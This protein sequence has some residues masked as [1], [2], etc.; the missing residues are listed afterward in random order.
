[1]PSIPSAARGIMVYPRW[2]SLLCALAWV[3][4]GSGVV[5]DV[6]ANLDP[7]VLKPACSTCRTNT[8]ITFKWTHIDHVVNSYE[9]EYI[10]SE[11]LKSLGGNAPICPVGQLCRDKSWASYRVTSWNLQRTYQLPEI[12][13]TVGCSVYNSKACQGNHSLDLRPSTLYA[14]RVKSCVSTTSCGVYS[15]ILFIPTGQ[16]ALSMPQKSPTFCSAVGA[17][18]GIMPHLAVTGQQKFIAM[19][20]TFDSEGLNKFILA[21]QGPNMALTVVATRD[22]DWAFAISKV[23]HYK[24]QS[25]YAT[26]TRKSLVW[27]EQQVYDGTIAFTAAAAT[28]AVGQDR[29]WSLTSGKGSGIYH[30]KFVVERDVDPP[31]TWVSLSLQAGYFV[32]SVAA[33]KDEWFVITSKGVCDLPAKCKQ[34]FIKSTDGT[35]PADKIDSLYAEGFRTTTMGF[36]N[37]VW[38]I[39][40]MTNTGFSDQIRIVSK[41]YPTESELQTYQTNGYRVTTAAGD[42]EDWVVVLSKISTFGEP[43]L[44]ECHN[45]GELDDTTC[46][47]KC[48][49]PWFGDTDIGGQKG[50]GCTLKPEPC[51]LSVF[52]EYQECPVTC[53]GDNRRRNRTIIREPQYGGTSCE[54]VNC[55]MNRQKFVEP[56]EDP[57]PLVWR[58]ETWLNMS[59]DNTFYLYDDKGIRRSSTPAPPDAKAVYAAGGITDVYRHK[60]LG[61]WF[62]IYLFWLDEVVDN[63]STYC[64]TLDTSASRPSWDMSY[65][66]FRHPL[67]C[68]VKG[69]NG[70]PVVKPAVNSTH[71]YRFRRGR[72]V[73]Y[74]LNPGDQDK[75][76]LA[77]VTYPIYRQDTGESLAKVWDKCK[78][79]SGCWEK[80][81]WQPLKRETLLQIQRPETAV[82]IDASG[83]F[84]EKDPK[85]ILAIEISEGGTQGELLLEGPIDMSPG[86]GFRITDSLCSKVNGNFVAKTISADLKT[87]SFEI[88]EGAGVTD[89]ND[90]G[91]GGQ[92][93]PTVMIPIDPSFTITWK[94]DAFAEDL[95]VVPILGGQ[96]RHLWVPAPV[97]P[98]FIDVNENFIRERIPE[99]RLIS[100]GNGDSAR[101]MALALRL[102]K[103]VEFKDV[104]KFGTFRI[105]I[106]IRDL[107]TAE[108]PPQTGMALIPIVVDNCEPPEVRVSW[109]PTVRVNPSDKTTFKGTVWFYGM[110]DLRRAPNA[111]RQMWV[112]NKQALTLNWRSIEAPGMHTLYET[113]DM[114]WN[115][116]FLKQ[117]FAQLQTMEGLQLSN[118][119][120]RKRSMDPG[121]YTF[122]FSASDL[123]SA[124][125]GEIYQDITVEV[126]TPPEGGQLLISNEG[127]WRHA[128]IFNESFELLMPGWNDTEL[129]IPL[130]YYYKYMLNEGSGWFTS[131]K[132]PCDI[133]D[134]DEETMCEEVPVSAQP[135]QL[136]HNA[137]AKFPAGQI[138]V[139]GYVV[140][141]NGAATRWI[142]LGDGTEGY[143]IANVSVWAPEMN[144]TEKMAMLA[145]QAEDLLGGNT[146]ADPDKAISS[147]NAMVGML[148]DANATVVCC[149]GHGNCT[150][151]PPDCDWP[152]D[153]MC[154][155]TQC[156]CEENWQ[157][158]FCET[159]SGELLVQKQKM[160]DDMMQ[161]MSGAANAT[162]G[163][164]NTNNTGGAAEALSKTLQKTTAGAGELSDNS[165][166][167]ATDMIFNL[168]EAGSKPGEQLPLDAGGPA[169]GA[170]ANLIKAALK[171]GSCGATGD[172]LADTLNDLGTALMG[173]NVP[174]EKSVSIAG[175]GIQMSVQPQTLDG[176]STLKFEVVPE[177]NCSAGPQFEFPV[178]LLGHEVDTSSEMA[179][180]GQKWDINRF[181]DGNVTKNDSVLGPAPSPW[182]GDVPEKVAAV[183][184]PSPGPSETNNTMISGGKSSAKPVKRGLSGMALNQRIHGLQYGSHIAFTMPLK[185][186]F[187]GGIRGSKCQYME[188][189]TNKFSQDGTFAIGLT[190]IKRC[191]VW[192]WQ[193]LCATSHLTDF[194]PE[195]EDAVPEMN[196]PDPIGDA[197]AVANFSA[198]SIHVPLILGILTLLNFAGIWYGVKNDRLDK[199]KYEA[200]MRIEFLKKGI[201]NGDINENASFV[202]MCMQ[203]IRATH[204]ILSF[205]KPPISNA[206]IFRR[207]ERV[208]CTYAH[209]LSSLAVSSLFYGKDPNSI[210]KK[211]S[212]SIITS[213]LMFP[214]SSAFPNSFMNIH[215]LKSKT[216]RKDEQVLDYAD[217]L[218]LSE[219]RLPDDFVKAGVGRDPHQERKAR[220]AAEK[221]RQEELEK[222]KQEAHD[223]EFGVLGGAAKKAMGSKVAPE[224]DSQ[225]KPLNWDVS[226]EENSGSGSEY[227]IES[228]SE[229]DVAKAKTPLMAR[230]A[231]AKAQKSGK[232]MKGPGAAHALM[233]AAARKHKL[234][235][236]ADGIE[237]IDHIHA[238]KLEALKHIHDKKSDVDSSNPQS[239][240]KAV[241]GRRK[242]RGKVKKIVKDPN[243]PPNKE[244]MDEYELGKYKLIVKKYNTKELVEELEKRGVEPALVYAN[245]ER[246]MEQLKN[247]T[248]DETRLTPDEIRDIMLEMSK[249]SEE[250]LVEQLKVAKVEPESKLEKDPVLLKQLMKNIDCIN[251]EDEKLEKNLKHMD[252]ESVINALK[253]RGVTPKTDLASREELIL[254]LEEYYGNAIL[255]YPEQLLKQLK[256]STLNKS[257]MSE[258]E[259]KSAS[260]EMS[261]MTETE[262]IEQLKIANVVPIDKPDESSLTEEEKKKKLDPVKEKARI[263]KLTQV[264]A[265]IEL[266]KLNLEPKRNGASLKELKQQLVHHIHG[267]EDDVEELKACVV[268]WDENRILQEMESY[269][270]EPAIE[271]APK[272]K[273]QA[274]LLAIRTKDAGYEKLS[275]KEKKAVQKQVK[276]YTV[277][278]L[279][280]EIEQCGQEPENVTAKIS[281]LKAQMLD[282]FDGGYDEDLEDSPEFSDK[283][284]KRMTLRQIEKEIKDRGGKIEYADAKKKVIYQQLYENT[285]FAKMDES[286]KKAR[287]KIMKS[288]DVLELKY[289][290]KKKGITPR[291]LLPER[292]ELVLELEQLLTTERYRRKMARKSQINTKIDPTDIDTTLVDPIDIEYEMDLLEEIG[293]VAREEKCPVRC[294]EMAKQ[295][296]MRWL[297]LVR[298]MEFE[299][300]VG[301]GSE[302]RVQ[303]YCICVALTFFCLFVIYMNLLFG[304]LFEPSQSLGWMMSCITTL[305]QGAVL[306]EPIG[307]C[308]GVL[309]GSKL[310]QLW[311]LLNN[312]GDKVDKE[313]DAAILVQ[314]AW[315]AKKEHRKYMAMLKDKRGA[316]VAMEETR[317]A[318][319]QKFADKHEREIQAATTIQAFM[320][321]C[322]D[323][324]RCVTIRRELKAR[325][326]R[327]RKQKRMNVMA[328]IKGQ[329][330]VSYNMSL[331]DKK[332]D[333]ERRRLEREAYMAA[334]VAKKDAARD[335]L[336]MKVAEGRMI[337]ESQDAMMDGFKLGAGKSHAHKGMGG[338]LVSTRSPDMPARSRRNAKTKKI[339]F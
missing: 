332:A 260:S 159:P 308:A 92:A 168:V 210:P 192:H 14:F 114:R 137:T 140:D 166:Q 322:W 339:S 30:Q 163:S 211:I 324:E 218:E 268:E 89:T 55:K 299:L 115:G 39:G 190:R 248:V 62:G 32:T 148:N 52:N 58:F 312:H 253:E 34:T 278:E 28:M 49:A 170:I 155:L 264:K 239:A 161:G 84:D 285:D 9:L 19:D 315:R 276:K 94:V 323:R 110:G 21:N 102:V 106:G 311:K 223:A 87:I 187:P 65:M 203:S 76:T 213:I 158:E 35:F 205:I 172:N 103:I 270:V 31:E 255:T 231:L 291:R 167:A 51:V 206:V 101:G 111:T 63:N 271:I 186:P 95:D 220:A 72:G 272:S 68:G 200:Y 67:R 6:A 226:D 259:Y 112:A 173:G 212:K 274:Q 241:S 10:L 118:F 75:Y 201:L 134:L 138:V 244:N 152:T 330:A 283:R 81:K 20:N 180:I 227:S 185:P 337:A 146:T 109:D 263:R 237:A 265:R 284:I 40:M 188:K 157:G 228:E 5:Q 326:A 113:P 27:M 197:G 261:K 46:T 125:R 74:E 36:R 176:M 290:L 60:E 153:L 99:S 130:T 88:S 246:L 269:G 204:K 78:S 235:N 222:I 43:C 42:E 242:K 307:I 142:Y 143:E 183:F 247:A 108:E 162:I 249:M 302:K 44:K 151:E 86:E 22:D 56:A 306:Y 300:Y 317:Q 338:K 288:M 314:T 165:T 105:Q 48:V 85:S 267:K 177:N 59:K 233:L 301:M 25:I 128:T 293:E 18:N 122:R 199:E 329:A 26:P 331:V 147:M 182:L 202:D 98:E 96:Q 178:S 225:K 77:G 309:M 266:E 240:E 298:R 232:A 100:I 70:A 193:M 252:E 15:Q 117:S 292:T 79:D 280:A 194:K 139:V 219:E 104:Q 328:R 156:D 61:T 8:S 24:T 184:S 256:D 38:W 236:N 69:C 107:G 234:K 275:D 333:E 215:S 214:T 304:V 66:E 136:Y 229:D 282:I 251:L 334:I 169:L 224:P 294:H 189:S 327:I 216:Y 141:S 195:V 196:T 64:D 175:G 126:N 281:I 135:P 287:L 3:L 262:L 91:Q 45:G 258:E 50:I 90:C 129:D 7:P 316:K 11:D 207:Y 191:G 198:D 150:F 217:V 71:L 181:G 4:M 97:S 313:L 310:P 318:E 297:L 254:Q 174:G 277:L 2:R 131:Q 230:I 273:L 133:E 209:F 47:C 321:G 171:G 23:P 93:T 13:P 83:S 1:M 279:I 160:R 80:E 37:R 325:T 221:K 127:I 54:I 29:S 305:L 123:C 250:E 41:T 295:E 335:F 319:I 73:D 119:I 121:F 289:E 16:D 257:R 208:A 144:D 320:R 164:N 238:R 57:E 245:K 154:A 53:G 243:A 124:D 145:K 82:I 149:G 179:L 120:V 33:S 336:Q 132:V 303:F 296:D 17:C 12:M 116:T 286:T